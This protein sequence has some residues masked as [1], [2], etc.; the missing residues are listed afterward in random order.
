MLQNLT[1]QGDPQEME[2]PLLL[3]EQH[4]FLKISKRM[5]EA[6]QDICNISL[7]EM[8]FL[9]HR[10][11]EE[12][13][14]YHNQLFRIMEENMLMDDGALTSLLVLQEVTTQSIVQKNATAYYIRSWTIPPATLRQHINDKYGVGGI[15]GKFY[16]TLKHVDM[17]TF[18]DMD[19]YEFHHARGIEGHLE[20]ANGRVFY[21]NRLFPWKESISQEIRRQTEAEDGT[22]V[23]PQAGLTDTIFRQALPHTIYDHVILVLVGNDITVTDYT[24]NC[25]FFDGS[26]AGDLTKK[27]LVRHK[28]GST[29]FENLDSN[30]NSAS[31]PF[32]DLF[33]WVNT[34]NTRNAA[35]RQLSEYMHIVQPVI[36]VA[37]SSLALNRLLDLTW[38]ITLVIG[39]LAIKY[40]E[41]ISRSNRGRLIYRIW[42]M[43]NPKSS[44]LDGRL[45]DLYDS[46]RETKDE[47]QAFRENRRRRNPP[48]VCR[49]TDDTIHEAVILRMERYG[50]AEHAP[51]SDDRRRQVDQ[52]WQ[53]YYPALHIHIPRSN[54]EEW[55]AWASNLKIGDH[56]FAS[57]MRHVCTSKH[58]P[59]RNAL[60][61][62]R[63]EGYDS[64][65][66]SWL[67]DEELVNATTTS[68]GAKMKEYLP[69]DHF[70]SE[71]QRRRRQCALVDQDIE[72]RLELKFPKYLVPQLDKKNRMFRVRFLE[73]GIGLD[74][75]DGKPFLG[76]NKERFLISC[77]RIQAAHDGLQLMR[78]WRRER[79]AITGMPVQVSVPI[80]NE[81]RDRPA[82]KNNTKEGKKVAFVFPIN[83]GAYSLGLLRTFLNTYFPNGGYITVAA[84]DVIPH[85]KQKKAT[86][87]QPLLETYLENNQEHPYYHEWKNWNDDIAK[88]GRHYFP[89]IKFLRPDAKIETDNEKV[90]VKGGVR[91]ASYIK[92]G[93]A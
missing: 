71:N 35:L 47:L 26:R 88:G 29:C 61:I 79:E 40:A 63:P 57:A 17:A 85:I 59:L 91:R 21:R 19:I 72:Q 12:T 65:D 45:S 78:L 69:D 74:Y 27:I 92:F 55:R 2:E 30:F 28:T 3:A 18:N 64:E 90:M 81:K 11:H 73:E 53:M 6:Q 16:N 89:N 44:N 15:L 14:E 60:N 77:T 56:F 87:I 9:L 93:P 75:I 49:A 8:T 22:Q 76:Q 7:D 62:Y 4:V 5:S 68:W 50:T 41:R 84:K 83:D 48:V 25:V 37:F 80:I 70:S 24:K 86:A 43:C 51:H 34:Q 54:E 39:E 82:W 38:T 66:E 58:H 36:T 1:I 42:E 13:T 46:L 31:F 33:P 10:N 20:E 23:I 32:I 52:L 67:N